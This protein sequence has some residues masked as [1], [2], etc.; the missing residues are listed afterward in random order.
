MAFTFATGPS[1]S[2]DTFWSALRQYF[3]HLVSWAEAGT[4]HYSTL[5]PTSSGGFQFSMAPFFAPN[6]TVA[7]A[8]ALLSPWYSQLSALNITVTPTVTSGSNF[9]D[10]WISAFALETVGRSGQLGSRLF[11]RQNFVD[12][13]LFNRTFDAIKAN[14]V[15]GNS[16]LGFNLA[17]TSQAGGHPQNSVNPAWRSTVLHALGFASWNVS[18]PAPEVAAIRDAFVN[19][20]MRRWRDVSPGSGAYLNEVRHPSVV[21]TIFSRAN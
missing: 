14:S 11:P 8:N 16:F 5:Y 21:F 19:G 15:A 6:K 20:P 4:Y 18:T 10:A 7:E 3:S 9:Y 1:L 13:A 17:P 2:L 12:G